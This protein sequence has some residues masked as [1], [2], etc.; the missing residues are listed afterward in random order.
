MSI[1]G[2]CRKPICSKCGRVLTDPVSIAMGIGPECR[3]RKAQLKASRME[4]TM[5]FR[6]GMPFTAGGS[7][8]TKQPGGWSN[9]K[10][11]FSETYL[12]KY[13][14]M[15]GFIEQDKGGVISNIHQSPRGE[16]NV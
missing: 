5:A 6:S 7:T 13:L 10:K 14:M 8:F 11:V 2:A 12:Q 15:N 16:E 4:R 1:Q 3:N 9:G